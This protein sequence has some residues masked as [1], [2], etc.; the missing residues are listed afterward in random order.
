MGGWMDAWMDGWLHGEEKKTCYVIKIT[1][2]PV[3]EGLSLPLLPS[4]R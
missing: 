1:K 3:A 4:P 2:Q